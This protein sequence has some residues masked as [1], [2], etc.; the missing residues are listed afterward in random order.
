MQTTVYAIE[1]Y[2][3]SDFQ[4]FTPL[5]DEDTQLHVECV[6]TANAVR[7]DY[8]VSGSPV[9]DEIEDIQIDEY[10]INGVEYTHKDLTAKFGDEL[11]DKLHVIC[12]DRAAEKDDW[13]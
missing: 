13:E 7:N 6:A 5:Y 1:S 2:D 9:W 12:A 4:E 3:I 8:G 11:A 10:E